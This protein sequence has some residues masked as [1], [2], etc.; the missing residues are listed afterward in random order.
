[1]TARIHLGSPLR[2]PDRSSLAAPALKTFRIEEYWIDPG[3]D[4]IKLRA[5]LGLGFGGI[6]ETCTEVMKIQREKEGE[7]IDY[8]MKL[9]F[10]C[11]YV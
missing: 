4:W 7:T 6:G 11:I 5:D 9:R 3:L 10:V 1:M 2:A 8:C